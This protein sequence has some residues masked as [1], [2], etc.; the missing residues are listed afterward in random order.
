MNCVWFGQ[1]L[2]SKVLEIR[3]GSEEELLH[4]CPSLIFLPWHLQCHRVGNKV[5]IHPAH[6]VTSFP[7]LLPQTLLL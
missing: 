7:R 5:S 3:E 1:S 4:D 6:Q 2:S